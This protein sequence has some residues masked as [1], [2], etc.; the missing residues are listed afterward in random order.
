MRGCP[1]YEEM[2]K[3]ALNMKPNN[4]PRVI[5]EVLESNSAPAN[6]IKGKLKPGS[7]GTNGGKTRVTIYGMSVIAA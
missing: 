2:I 4:I 3:T 5:L 1:A 7:A 6:T